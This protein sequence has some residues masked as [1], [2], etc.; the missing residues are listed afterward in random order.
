MFISAENLIEIEYPCFMFFFFYYY[1]VFFSWKKKGSIL[2][3]IY[4]TFYLFIL[5]IIVVIILDIFAIF[6]LSEVL[7]W[8]FFY[9]SIAP[10]KRSLVPIRSI[11]THCRLSWLSHTIYWKSPISN[12]GTSGYEIHISLQK[13]G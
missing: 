11:L 13:N 6:T 9:N 10:D 7:H 3:V 12:L 1:I 2:S 5:F 4:M 8:R